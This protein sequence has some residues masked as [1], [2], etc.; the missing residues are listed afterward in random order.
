MVFFSIKRYYSTAF[1][2]SV[3]K[4]VKTEGDDGS[5]VVTTE[6]AEDAAFVAKGIGLVLGAGQEGVIHDIGP[7]ITPATG[8]FPFRGERYLEQ[9]NGP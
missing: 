6:D 4:R 5:S 3:L 7:F 1:L 8:R 2:S 9:V